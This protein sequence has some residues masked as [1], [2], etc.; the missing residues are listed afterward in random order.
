VVVDAALRACIGGG[1]D[2]DAP[3]QRREEGTQSQEPGAQDSSRPACLLYVAEAGGGGGGRGR[4]RTTAQHRKQRPVAPR[5]T[6]RDDA[7]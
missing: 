1:R 2:C 4:P 7:L 5:P 3:P 6:D